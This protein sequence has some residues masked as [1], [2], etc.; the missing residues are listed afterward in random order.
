[1]EIS[2]TFHVNLNGYNYFSTPTKAAKG[3][4]ILYVKNQYITK[5][6]CDLDKILYKSKELESVF[7]EICNNNKKNFIVGCIYRHPNMDLELF[8]N[9]FLHP[10]L[11]K[12][13]NERKRVFLI[14]DFN[15]NLMNVNNNTETCNFFDRISSSL[16]VPHIIHPTRYSS[17]GKTLID[18][19]FSNCTNFR[20]G[21]SG[22]LT[23]AISDHLPQFLFI[24]LDVSSHKNK[25]NKS[26]RDF[27]RFN[28]ENFILDFLSID[29]EEIIRK[30][31]DPNVAFNL[32][33]DKIDTLVNNHLPLRKMT[34]KENKTISKPWITTG[35]CNSIKRKEI[36]YRKIVKEKDPVKKTLLN[37]EF[38]ILRNSI[39]TLCKESKKI[40]FSEYFDINSRNLKS[41][42]KGI[43]QI[44]NSK[45]RNSS[46]PSC[47][48]V[49]KKLIHDEKEMAKSFNEF[50]TSIAGKLKE[51]IYQN[52]KNNF[53]N[54]L[55]QPCHQSFFISP[56]NSSEILEVINKM[57][58][59]KAS[60]PYSIPYSVL[61]IIDKTFS[62]T[63]ASLINRSFEEGIFFERLKTSKVL[64]IL[65]D[66][67]N[68]LDMNNYRPISL[69]S[70]MN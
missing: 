30:N 46:T 54:Y 43:N 49:D 40:H 25:T 31:N 62:K 2:P 36:L 59:S 23:V 15:I 10:L 16:L 29:F 44:I 45:S 58:G 67:D 35:I 24:D 68:P 20:E 13:D 32:C 41:T 64:P 47:I 60:G 61:V 14:G 56:T 53:K 65:K 6:R 69:L 37:N 22:N 19:I 55:S 8:N 34:K 1:M 39:T 18:N 28:K 4:A 17:H 9:E 50:F 38:K 51:K 5:R 52:P 21:I 70:N 63:L 57:N 33:M 48:S 12:L 3:G 66:P 11:S 7:V 27:K 42:W 26:I